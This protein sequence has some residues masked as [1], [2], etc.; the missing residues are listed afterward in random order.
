M[1]NQYAPVSPAIAAGLPQAFGRFLCLFGIA[2]FLCL[3]S[4]GQVYTG[5]LTGVVKDPS[6][7]VVPNASAVLTDADKGF[8]YASL[9]DTEG[10]YMLR[11]LPPGRYSLKVTAAGMRPYTPP[12]LTL[13]VGQNAEVNVDFEIQGTAEKVDVEATATLL[14]TQDASTGYW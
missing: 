9:T 1:P 8:T 13:T 4:L 12:P 14:Q 2:A 10:R 5:S 3:V 11:N 6:T 7:A